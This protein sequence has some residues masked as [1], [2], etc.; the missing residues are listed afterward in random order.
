MAVGDHR[1]LVRGLRSDPASKT[2]VDPRMKSFDPSVHHFRKTGDLSNVGDRRNQRRSELPPLSR[3]S[4]GDRRRYGA[5]ALRQIKEAGLVGNG[6]KRSPDP[7][8]I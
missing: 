4:K 8:D 5:S 7:D 3:P 2:A 6:E 1:R